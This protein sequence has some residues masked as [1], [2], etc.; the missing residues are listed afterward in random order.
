MSSET[1]WIQ[2]KSLYLHLMERKEHCV[3]VD[4]PAELMNEYDGQEKTISETTKCP[5]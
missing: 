1:E 5:Q 4:K 3:V 2:K